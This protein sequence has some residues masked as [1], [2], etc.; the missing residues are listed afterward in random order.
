MSQWIYNAEP[1]EP[2][3]LENWVGFVYLITDLENNKKYIGKKNFWSTRR[4]P[5][6]KGKTRRRV[7][8]VESDWKEYYGSNEKIK[9][10]VE[11]FSGDRFKREILHLCKS[12]GEMSYVEAKLQFEHEV[13]FRDDYYNEFIG[14]KCHSKHVKNMCTNQ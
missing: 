6:L 8:K 10:L 13:L 14:L 3:Q 11:E 5:P 1:F 2:T 7:K 9:L 12:K 4:L